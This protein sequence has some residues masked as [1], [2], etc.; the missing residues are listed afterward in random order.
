VNGCFI[1]AAAAGVFQDEPARV[2]IYFLTKIHE[3]I[4]RMFWRKKQLPWYLKA[5]FIL[6]ILRVIYAFAKFFMKAADK[7]AGMTGASI[8]NK[9]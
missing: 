5:L 9:K 7:H 1:I 2:Y 3:A 8:N 4:T 6:I